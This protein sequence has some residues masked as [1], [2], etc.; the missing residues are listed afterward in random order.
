MRKFSALELLHPDGSVSTSWVVGNK[1][2]EGLLP[3]AP[4]EPVARV[5]LFI[6]APSAEECSSA[7]WLER[8][9]ES[10][11]QRLSDDGLG[12]VLAPFRWRHKII[13]LLRRAGLEIGPSFWHF[14]DWASSHYLVPLQRGPAQFAVESIIPAPSWKRTLARQMLRHSGTRRFLSIFWHS[15]GI[16]VRRP[17][18]R[19]LFHWLFQRTRTEFSSETAI[20]RRSWRAPRGAN[21]LYCFTDGGLRPSALTK[22]TFVENFSAY[23]DQEADALEN[24]GPGAR[25]AGAQIPRVLRQEQ[26]GPY[27]CLSLSFLPGQP[28][29]DLLDTNPDLLAPI[30]TKIVHWLEQWYLGTGVIRRLE[31]EQLEQALLAP[32]ELLAAHLQNAEEY[33]DWL[34]DRIRSTLGTPMPFAA[35]HNDLTMANIL[36]DEQERLGVVDWETAL[37]RSWPLVDF[38]YTVTDAVRIAQKRNSW[39]EAFEACYQ[40]GGLY[41][42]QVAGWEEQLRLA[43]ELPPALAEICFHACWLHHASNEHRVS[44]PGAPR[45]FLQIVQWLALHYEKASENRN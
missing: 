5:D 26:N 14:P 36:L 45:P 11:S 10:L 29:S 31:K 42:P 39:P 2:P 40:P 43:T 17:G 18:A 16:S 1:C 37:A 30:L 9:V 8:V 4:I 25:S 28:A 27:S 33:R 3:Q 38:Y 41:T 19:T 6:L 7:G 44:Q 15:A 34:V 20:V 32:L 12:Y 21:L 13:S 23:P 22:I 35:A 24:L